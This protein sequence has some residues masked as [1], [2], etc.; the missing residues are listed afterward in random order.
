MN[1]SFILR[2]KPCLH[3]ITWKYVVNHCKIVYTCEIIFFH[4]CQFHR[5][6]WRQKYLCCLFM[7][8]QC[9]SNPPYFGVFP[10]ISKPASSCSAARG[11]VS[12]PG[13]PRSHMREWPG[14]SGDL[15]SG[16]GGG[17]REWPGHSGNL[18]N[19]PGGGQWL[20]A[21]ILD[22]LTQNPA[23]WPSSR[24]HKLTH[25]KAFNDILFCLYKPERIL[26]AIKSPDRC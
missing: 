20:Q 25:L 16:P 9:L 8:V 23:L 6:K 5:H 19:G 4:L 15:C 2:K 17:M 1:I 3:Y 24:F 13:S 11:L 7:A 10:W 14:H 12:H 22:M 18:W 26:F 21:L